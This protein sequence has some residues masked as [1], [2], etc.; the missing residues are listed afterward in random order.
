MG[1][2]VSPLY[3][4]SLSLSFSLSRLPT[5][6]WLLAFGSLFPPFSLIYLFFFL[7]QI[8]IMMMMIIIQN[9]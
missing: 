3:F 5:G 2:E 4:L 1:T 7:F 9:Y 6:F 8:T